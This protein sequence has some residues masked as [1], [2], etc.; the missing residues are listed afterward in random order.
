[1]LDTLVAKLRRSRPIAL[2]AALAVG[3]GSCTA[4]EPASLAQRPLRIAIARA[5][6]MLDPHL[7]SEMP[8][9]QALGNIYECLVAL[10]YHL[11]PVPMLAESWENPD[12]LS[13]RFVLRPGSRF[14]DGQPL[15]AEDV[16]YSLERAQNHPKS[17]VGGM[18][19]GI[20]EARALN[21]TTVELK[22][23]EPSPILLNR[24]AQI[25]IVPRGSSE[26]IT[27]PI[28]S[29]PYRVAQQGRN[30]LRLEA[31]PQ[32]R[33]FAQSSGRKPPRQ[34]ELHFEG[35]PATRVAGLLSGRFDLIEELPP[36]RV[37]EIAQ[38]SE[39]RVHSVGSLDLNNLHFNLR[40]SP[41]NDW[42]VRRAVDLLLDREELV[43]AALAGHGQALGQLAT[44]YVFGFDPKRLPTR[45]D[46]DTARQLLKEAGLA[47]GFDMT[48]EY[49]EGTS[50]RALE[51]MVGQLAA[52]GIRVIEQPLPWPV[53][54][55]RF[56]QGETDVFLGSYVFLTGDASE[57]LDPALHSPDLAR[58][59]GGENVS[60]Y[61]NLQLDALIDASHLATS[62]IDRG[63]LL[64]RAIAL[65]S[66]DLALLPLYSAN[67]L[68]GSQR[69]LAWTPRR[70]G[71]IFA[72]EISW[73][74]SENSP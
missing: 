13:W 21:R 17:L 5:P 47:A 11:R 67:N 60:H 46:P 27:W 70:D 22:T 50:R 9:F 4:S 64:Q 7:Q 54:Y 44:P 39:L 3:L 41:W 43:R 25:A 15:E 62:E 36:D 38:R 28:G 23:S 52:G 45:R 57:L 16:I 6:S 29:G 32:H 71:R 33:I 24:L 18:L 58:G 56:L 40:R 31:D 1:M 37:D 72:F 59:L 10:D 26:E 51:A 61:S 34:V 2:I 30:L 8:A 48:V 53:L 35:S 73:R 65:A 55:R 49:R 63:L 69:N 19:V 42:R 66:D 14:Q 74:S 12:P 68:T 20:R